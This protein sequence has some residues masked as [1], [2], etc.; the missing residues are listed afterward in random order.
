MENWA[1]YNQTTQSE[2]SRRL[3]PVFLRRFAA[4]SRRPGPAREH[5]SAYNQTTQPDASRYLPTIFFRCFPAGSRRPGSAREHS[6]AYKRTTQPEAKTPCL[7]LF[8][9]RFSLAGS[10]PRGPAMISAVYNATTEPEAKS[11]RRLPLGCTLRHL[12]GWRLPV[13]VFQ[14]KIAPETHDHG[15]LLHETSLHVRRPWAHQIFSLVAV[16]CEELVQEC[17]NCSPLYY[18]EFAS[19]SAFLLSLLFLYVYCTDLYESLGEDKV[20]KL[21]FLTVLLIVAIFLS[22]SILLSANCN[23]P[24][25]YAACVFGFFATSVFVAELVIEICLRIKQKRNVKK[26]PEK[27]PNA[28]RATEN[29]PLNKKR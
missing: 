14:T 12:R 20:R 5:S 16:V 15:G 10:R 11:P 18:F 7:P 24:E 8:C 19:C 25:E 9:F 27:P 28:P 21:N 29:Q 2:A 1:A 23:E 22:A 3:P 17:Y 13:K 26:H 4:G 6:S